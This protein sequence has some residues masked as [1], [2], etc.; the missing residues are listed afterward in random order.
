MT[1]PP[2]KITP[3]NRHIKIIKKTPSEL[4]MQKNAQPPKTIETKSH[5]T[6]S[7]PVLPGLKELQT[8]VKSLLTPLKQSEGSRNK[9]QTTAQTSSVK[10]TIPRVS[11]FSNPKEGQSRNH[12]LNNMV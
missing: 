1:K 5:L 8:Q 7:H 6:L 12:Q 9:I 10:T 2:T 11:I 4:R 3:P